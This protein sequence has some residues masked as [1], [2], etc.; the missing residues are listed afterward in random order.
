MKCE[1][2]EEKNGNNNNERSSHWRMRFLQWR[3]TGAGIE[4][5]K[6]G[7]EKM[8]NENNPI[9][10]SNKKKQRVI[11]IFQRVCTFHTMHSVFFCA[12]YPKLSKKI[13]ESSLN[14]ANTNKWT[15]TF[16]A[17]H[18]AH[19]AIVLFIILHV[20]F[21]SLSCTRSFLSQSRAFSQT[22]IN[23]FYIRNVLIMIIKP[24][25]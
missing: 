4:R 23:H 14:P 10:A 20:V 24:Y 19:R 25:E 12:L 22:A 13:F 15:T 9:H 5:G 7:S 16:R 11:W 8:N 2:I 17:E 6:K 1:T 18:T 21:D 3:W